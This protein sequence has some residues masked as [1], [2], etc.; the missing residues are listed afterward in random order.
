[1]LPP[2]FHKRRGAIFHQDWASEC[3]GWKILVSFD[4]VD[5]PV[6]GDVLLEAERVKLNFR[7]DLLGMLLF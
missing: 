3:W 4:S 6:L 5:Y 7:Q 2:K 1:M